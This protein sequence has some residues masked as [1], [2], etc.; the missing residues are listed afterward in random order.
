MK[1]RYIKSAEQ[2]AAFHFSV[3]EYFMEY[4]PI[5]QPIFMI[6]QADKCAMVGAYQVAQAEIDLIFAEKAGIQIVRRQSGGGTIF[7]D[8]GT[9]LY[10]LILPDASGQLPREIVREIFAA[11]MVRALNKFGVPAKMEGRNDILADGKKFSGLAQYVRNGRICSHGSLLYNTNLD[12]LTEVLRVDAEKIDSKAIKSVRSRVVNLIEYMAPPVSV[13]Q[14]W[15]MLEEKLTQE[16]SL[17]PHSLTQFD[18]EK[19]NEIYNAKY[20][21]PDWTFGKS[22]KFS[23]N[24]SRRFAGGKVEVFLNIMRGAVIECAIRGDFLGTKSIR[25]LEEIIESCEFTY[26]SIKEKI[27][28]VDIPSYLGDVTEDEL[29]SCMFD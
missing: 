10:T 16:W 20:G 15:N 18:L 4:A 7:T 19:I 3:E 5:D 1:L 27:S 21:N 17:E 24:N 14:F 28:P 2:D 12:M 25:E 26:K 23:F 11:P 6:W 8:L 13:Q 22:P 9:L 29:L